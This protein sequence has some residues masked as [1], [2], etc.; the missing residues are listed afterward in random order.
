MTARR[1][2][3]LCLFVVI[4]L[5]GA[6]GLRIW[7]TAQ[8]R[9][10]PA[11]SHPLP[12]APVPVPP[13]RGDIPVSEALPSPDRPRPAGEISIEDALAPGLADEWIEFERLPGGLLLPVMPM[14]ME[15]AIWRAYQMIATNPAA[16]AAELGAQMLSATSAWVRATGAIWLLE[17]NRRLEPE[18]QDRLLADES[19]L[20]PLTVLGW[21]LDSGYDAEAGQFDARWQSAPQDARQAAIQAVA[22]ESLNGM[23]GR[24]ALWLADRSDWTPEEK[25]DW[26]AEV[27]EN[28]DAAYDVRWKAAMMARRHMNPAD[29][30]QLVLDLL[31]V[32]SLPAPFPPEHPEEDSGADIPPFTIAMGL[33]NER[34]AGPPELAVRT[35]LTGEDADRLFDQE[36]SLMLENIA[37]WIEAALD[38][39]A[40]EAE[41]GFAA[42]ITRHLADLPV[43]ELPANQRL[44][45]RRL[46]ARLEA[47]ARQTP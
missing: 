23:A 2:F 34:L 38:R 28:G 32:D 37:L 27:A 30:R 12:D 26:M 18:I 41:P 31:E 25:G 21:M 35:V 3:I 4:L 13:P 44:A 22:E 7:R 47:L 42:A 43:E 15:A 19:A 39:A 40:V 16:D 45:L 17:K 20:V 46:Q 36:S 29:Y 14:K 11:V 9:T 33:L 8:V 6:A 24:A 1:G 5:I 10:P